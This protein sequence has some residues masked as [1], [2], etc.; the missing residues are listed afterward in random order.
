[1]KYKYII[2][3]FGNV[4]VTPTTGNWDITPKFLKLIDV[5]KINID[6]FNRYI[7][8]DRTN[9]VFNLAQVL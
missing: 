7:A 9:Q 3:D 6:K 4:L 2:L 8:N 5:D 1:M